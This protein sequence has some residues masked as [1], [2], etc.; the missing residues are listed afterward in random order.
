MNWRKVIG[1]IVG[2]IVIIFLVTILSKQWSQIQQYEWTFHLG[3]L[4]LSILFLT[5]STLIVTL[6]SLTVFREFKESISFLKIFNIFNI[7]APIRYIPGNVWY[8]AGRMEMFKKHKVS[9]LTSTVGLFLEIGIGLIAASTLFLFAIL[10]GYDLV[11]I[12]S[13]WIILIIVTM[14]ISMH[15]KL[16][17]PII[18]KLYKLVK[19]QEINLTWNYESTLEIYI[20]LLSHWILQ[21]LAFFFLVKSIYITNDTILIPLIGIYSIAWVL[22][23]LT[24]ISPGGLGIK[25]G[26]MVLFLQSFMPLD[27]SIIISLF[28]RIVTIFHELLMASISIL[29]RRLE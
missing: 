6:S 20:I 23:F 8:V 13:T 2:V 14:V 18:N 10:L 12:S 15:P 9:R 4:F 17:N 28:S 22:S 7:S 1:F 29:L 3:W 19:K 26:I 24:F 16:F 25:E 11:N 21:G 27:V 5:I